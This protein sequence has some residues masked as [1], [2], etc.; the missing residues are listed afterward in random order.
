MWVSSLVSNDD[1]V[2]Y[3]TIAIKY[4]SATSTTT[5]PKAHQL[6]V[7]DNIALNGRHRSITVDPGAIIQR[8]AV[9]DGEAAEHTTAA[10]CAGKGHH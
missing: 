7:G 10:F 2:L 1:I 5:P 6:I 4:A 3:Q 8:L 9:G